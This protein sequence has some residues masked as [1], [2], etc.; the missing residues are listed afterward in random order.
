M[1][2]LNSLPHLLLTTF[3][4]CLDALSFIRLSPQHTWALATENL[5][6]QLALYLSEGESL[7]GRTNSGIRC[8]SLFR[9]SPS[10][11][12]LVET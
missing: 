10:R 12:L 2:K 6:K 1:F 11:W 4:L 3:D 5:R 7:I 8:F 9:L